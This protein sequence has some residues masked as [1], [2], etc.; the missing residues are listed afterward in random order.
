MKRS[1]AILSLLL[2][3]ACQK[4]DVEYL[5]PFGTPTRPFSPH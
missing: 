3:T 5:T 2:A 4:V 1:L